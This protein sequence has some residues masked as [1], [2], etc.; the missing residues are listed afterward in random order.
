MFLAECQAEK[1]SFVIGIPLIYE[2]ESKTLNEKL[3][4]N[5]WKQPENKN[6]I[7]Q[8]ERNSIIMGY[9]RTQ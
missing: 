4:W 8:E 9:E 6:K 7:L 5:A 2:F 3:L 1:R